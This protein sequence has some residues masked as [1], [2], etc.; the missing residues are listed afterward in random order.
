[1][2]DVLTDFGLEYIWPYI[3]KEIDKEVEVLLLID[4]FKSLDS[5]G[6]NKISSNEYF[7]KV[8]KCIVSLKYRVTLD[9]WT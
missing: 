5:P 1:M 6:V 2:L 9:F 3:P 4:Q 7:K 8:L